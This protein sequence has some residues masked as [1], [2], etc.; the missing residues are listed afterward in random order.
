MG[1]RLFLLALG[2][3]FA[4]SML[5]YVLIRFS[6][7]GPAAGTLHLPPLLLLSTML[8]LAS[9]FTMQRAL[10][11]GRRADTAALRRSMLMT[12]VLAGAFIL[13][14]TPALLSLLAQHGKFRG[15]GIGLY[16]LIFF[17]ILLHAM[18][19][20]GG[21]VALV[22]AAAGAWGGAAAHNQP[23]LRY[24]SMYWHFLDGVWL[25]LFAVLWLSR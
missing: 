25:A 4:A 14:Q 21:I 20:V 18:H 2:I 15:T 11:A 19:V 13:V 12:L 24:A 8:M 5:G 10:A 3:L 16:G 7:R 6:P 9:S 17:L 1:M 23:V 22:R